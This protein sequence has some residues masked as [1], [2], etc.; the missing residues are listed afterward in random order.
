MWLVDY[1]GNENILLSSSDL[2]TFVLK[3]EITAVLFSS[4]PFISTE[5]RLTIKKR[6]YIKVISTKMRNFN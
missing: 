6:K 5:W 1:V 3:L 4:L 2:R